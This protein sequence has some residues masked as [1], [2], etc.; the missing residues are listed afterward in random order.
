[1]VGVQAE[2]QD[3]TYRYAALCSQVTSYLGFPS[4]LVRIMFNCTDQEN[5]NNSGLNQIHISIP[6]CGN[7]SGAQLL[8][9]CCFIIF[10]TSEVLAH[11]FTFLSFHP[12]VREQKEGGDQEVL[13]LPVPSQEDFLELTHKT[14]L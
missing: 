12:Y 7:A 10:S 9:T 4:V 6:F 1:M 14:T 13:M 11:F 8:F 3:G 5:P 2:K